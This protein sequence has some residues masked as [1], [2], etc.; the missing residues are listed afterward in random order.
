MGDHVLV[1]GASLMDTKGKPTAGLE[2]GTS[3]PGRIRTTRGGS[4][5][6]VAE[7]LG[8]LGADVVL[9][10]AVGD[11]LLGQRLLTHTTDAGVDTSRVQVVR[12]ERTGSYMALLEPDGTLA[13]ALDDTAVMAQI[14]PAFLYQQ[15]SLFRDADMVMVDGSLTP[16]ALET[17]V[18][19]AVKYN[20]PICADPASSR[21]AH[22]LLPHLTKLTLAV[23]NEL[24]ASVLCDSDLPG[25]EPEDRIFLARQLNGRGVRKAVITLSDFGLVYATAEEN[26]YIPARYSEMRDSTGTGD[27]ITAAI[28]F[29]MINDLEDLECMRLGAA[30]AGLTL[31]TN[32]TVVP[33]LSLDL[34]YNH[35]I[36]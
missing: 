27:A 12:G 26:G 35:L 20:L 36:V 19:L 31:Q 30:A 8:R 3:N 32:E 9:L 34:L 11:D 14:S 13:V 23:P 18:G 16:A 5:R 4:A 10:S 2:P 25:I 33:D 28:I 7:N 15:R 17:A 6:N 1:I 24:E 21:L 22:K 29:G